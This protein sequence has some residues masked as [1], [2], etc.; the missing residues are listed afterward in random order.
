MR[1][2][3]WITLRTLSIKIRLLVLSLIP[4]SVIIAFTTHFAADVE[5]RLQQ[6]ALVG[7]RATI[8]ENLSQFS[9][10][11]HQI[12]KNAIMGEPV[13]DK[14]EQ[15][16]LPLNAIQE[17]LSQDNDFSLY[18]DQHQKI[19]S[20]AKDLSTLVRDLH[21][22]GVEESIESGQLIFELLGD[23]YIEIQNLSGFASSAEVNKLDSV[24]TQLYWLHL[25]MEKEA[26][27]VEQARAQ[28]WRYDRY[29][30][31]YY[32]ISERQQYYLDQFINVG[33]DQQQVEQLLNL[34]AS[35][36]FRKAM[37][38]RERLMSPQATGND[39]DAAAFAI[40]QRNALVKQQLSAFSRQFQQQLAELISTERQRLIAVT[41]ATLVLLLMMF[42]W[43]A[44]TFYRINSK[45][46]RILQSMNALRRNDGNETPFIQVDGNDEFTAFAGNLNHV[47]QEQI[48]YEEQLLSA[49]EQAEA[50]NRTKSMFL[51]NMSHEIRTPLNGIIGM[52]EILYDSHLTHSQKDILADIDTSSQSLLVLINDILDLSKIESGNLVLTPHEVGV[53][54]LVFETVNMVCT[55]AL[56][57]Q[58][59]LFI[60]LDTALPGV[61][62][63]DEF[64]FKQV[65]LNLL[66]NAVKFTHEGFVSVELGYVFD[67]HTHYLNC[68]V[69]DSG[70]GI[71]KEKQQT[72]FEPF[73]QEDGSITRRFGGTGLGLTICK[74]II[75]LMG[76]KIAVESTPS[77]GS[78]F[79]FTIPVEVSKPLSSPLLGCS[80]HALLVVNG[81]KHQHLVKQECLRL[82]L[83]ISVVNDVER[84]SDSRTDVDVILYFKA[85]EQ[86]SR[87][88]LETLHGQFPLAQLVLLQH[89]LFIAQD[90]E[91]WV[92]A[93]I[94]LP[95]LGQRFESVLKTLQHSSIKSPTSD[96]IYEEP[97]AN[98][99]HQR[100]LIV[101]DNL[102][103]QKIASFFLS[104]VGMEYRIASNGQEALN[105]GRDG[106]RFSAILMD[107]MMPVMD[108]LTATK[109]IRQWEKEQGLERTPIIALTASVLEEEI[110]SCF[111]SGMDAYLPKPYKSQQ[112]FDTLER[113]RVGV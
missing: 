32:H 30:S 46:G 77:L 79:E 83:Q 28:S 23:S 49:K 103:N 111:A 72:I 104:K 76:G 18:T 61:I 54:N 43:G 112:L 73:T 4:A 97:Q 35:A 38:V 50:A 42:F 11:T 66:S 3:S 89:H 12:L 31:E 39:I 90:L 96:A 24:L 88:D 86:G 25:W 10:A 63:I 106:D 27:Y 20:Y 71:D 6:M 36:S 1:F 8:L 99:A 81:S 53:H 7:E 101:E 92:T 78:C 62:K 34:F 110:E 87:K 48:R 14:L 85:K 60:Q 84:M 113:L 52:T 9:N 109:N 91:N 33:A 13:Q 21:Y 69:I 40:E 80:L 68:A 74:Q 57:Q 95:I 47:I 59:E 22:V 82:G 98:N 15:T 45:L 105:F 107:C 93:S 67:G 64:R 19:V 26:W 100:V 75:D 29:S 51:A 44:S 16:V 108:G 55:K 17:M 58:N 56:K 94:T 41:T 102:M 2:T 65:L 37:Q 70:V 5:Q